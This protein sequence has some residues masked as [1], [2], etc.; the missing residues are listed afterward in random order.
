MTENEWR[1]E[2]QVEW[3]RVEEL[4][5]HLEECWGKNGAIENLLSL[6]SELKRRLKRL[7]EISGG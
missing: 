3:E 4:I 6:A 2:A 1:T 7:R 5:Y